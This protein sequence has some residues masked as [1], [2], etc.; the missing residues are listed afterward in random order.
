MPEEISEMFSSISPRY[1]LMNHLFSLNIDK[2][3]RDDAAREA[4]IGKRSYSVLDI[5]AGTCDLSMAVSRMASGRG[6]KV[7]VYASDFNSSMLAIGKLKI[8]REGMGNIETELAN[9]FSMRHRAASIDVL[10]SGFALRSF[11]FSKGGYGNLRRFLSESYRVLKP[12]GK[13]V[14]L[15]MAMPDG[16]F[17]RS[18]F[19]AY[20]GFMLFLGSFVDFETYRWLVDTIKKFDKGELL[21]IMEAAGFRKIRTR[22]LR[23]GIA[24]I[25]T[26]Y[27]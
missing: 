9:A 22:N 13:V 6:K 23:S 27:K 26:A 17:Q 12:G 15:D 18:F 5:A 3:W 4:I 25:V 14:L 10:T 19:T 20:S 2:S 16:R 11:A 24:Y 7:H 21:R 1:D 8:R